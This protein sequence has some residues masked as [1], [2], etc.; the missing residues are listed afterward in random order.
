MSGKSMAAAWALTL[1]QVVPYPY[2]WLLWAAQG[3]GFA[4]IGF[5]IGHDAIHVRGA[6]LQAC[7]DP[8]LASVAQTQDRVI[9]TRDHD[10]SPMAV[11][12]AVRLVAAARAQRGHGT[13]LGPG[14][15]DLARGHRR[16]GGERLGRDLHP[17]IALDVDVGDGHDVIG[18]EVV[19][20]RPGRAPVAGQKRFRPPARPAPYQNPGSG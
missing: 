5:N 9:V 12:G 17:T 7:S 3:F 19:A 20:Q 4:C 11:A 14:P 18:N 13:A 16:I 6:G 1:A 8:N 15:G 2:A 10:F